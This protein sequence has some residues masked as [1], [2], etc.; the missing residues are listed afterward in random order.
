MQTASK[1]F[2][3]GLGFSVLY[4]Q[5]LTD[6][7]WLTGLPKGSELRNVN[8][9][10]PELSPLGRVEITAHEGYP[11]ADKRTVAVP[12]NIG[13]LALSFETDDLAGTSDLVTSLG[14][15]AIADKASLT[16][17]PWGDI[18]LQT[19]HGLNGEVLEIFQRDD[20]RLGYDVGKSISDLHHL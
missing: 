16:M 12:P 11:G 1:L 17:P 4:D 20:G 6:V 18:H 15:V 8:L 9:Q 5:I 2:I 3:K 14:G 10:K 13:I 19:F 7:E